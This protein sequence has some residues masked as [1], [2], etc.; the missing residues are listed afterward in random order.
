MAV[1]T[2]IVGIKNLRQVGAHA[3]QPSQHASKGKPIPFHDEIPLLRRERLLERV[4]LGPAAEPHLPKTPRLST[5]VN[6]RKKPPSQMHIRR[7]GG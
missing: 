2:D 7:S 3:A 4:T 5:A 1:R 6:G